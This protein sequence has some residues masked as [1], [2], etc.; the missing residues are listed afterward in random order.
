MK[1]EKYDIVGDY[2]YGFKTETDAV[3][4]TKKA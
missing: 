1:K 3:F 2:K 4:K